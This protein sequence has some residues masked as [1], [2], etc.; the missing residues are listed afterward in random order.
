MGL[1]PRCACSA[2]CRMACTAAGCLMQLTAADMQRWPLAMC[3]V[4]WW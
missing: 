4:M 2:L 3:E 1:W